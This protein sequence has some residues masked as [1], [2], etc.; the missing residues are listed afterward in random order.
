M[1]ASGLP[2]LK[3]QRKVHMAP[4][5]GYPISPGGSLARLPEPSEDSLAHPWAVRRTMSSPTTST[6]TTTAH[7]LGFIVQVCNRKVKHPPPNKIAA[8]EEK[9]KRKKQNT[10]ETTVEGLFN[11]RWPH[12]GWA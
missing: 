2:H 6:A 12:I 8:T 1:K 9:S 11:K 7:R 10:I 4:T 3:D 5:K